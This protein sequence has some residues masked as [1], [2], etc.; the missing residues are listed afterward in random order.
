MMLSKIISK[1]VI[2]I[3]YE[4]SVNYYNKK[5]WNIVKLTKYGPDIQ[6]ECT[7]GEIGYLKDMN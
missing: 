7:V 5:L 3:T 6:G 1:V 4:N 2:N